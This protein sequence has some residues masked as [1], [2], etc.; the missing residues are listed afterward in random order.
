MTTKSP[1]WLVQSSFKIG[2]NSPMTTLKFRTFKGLRVFAVLSTGY[3]R[4][5]GDNCIYH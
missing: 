1:K 3:I 2:Q 5:I 4:G